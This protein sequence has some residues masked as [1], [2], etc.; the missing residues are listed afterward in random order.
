MWLSIKTCGL[1]RI[2]L[3]SSADVIMIKKREHEI[4]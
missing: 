1:V 3:S 2:G 4:D